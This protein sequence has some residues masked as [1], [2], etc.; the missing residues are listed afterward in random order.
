MQT[1]LIIIHVII[2]A[3]LIAVV[4]MQHGKQEGLSGAIA[5][6]AETFFGRNKGR[7]IDAMLKKVTTVVACLF[8]ISSIVLAVYSINRNNAATNPAATDSAQT[9]TTNG[10]AAGN[11]AEATLNKDG[12]LVDANG[13]VLMTAEDI[14]KGQEEAKANTDDKA[15]S[16]A[17]DE[18]KKAD[19]AK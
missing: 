12:N 1:A 13:N 3:V 7:T 17:N 9:E 11:S 18:T 2:S 6:G 4:L 5:G 15:A 16:S 8:V 10:A 14:K 19:E